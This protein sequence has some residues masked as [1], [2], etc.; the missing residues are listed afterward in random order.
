MHDLDR[1]T[2]ESNYEA[3]SYEAEGEAEVLGE[4][5]LNELTGGLL[6][7]GGE[8]E[9][10]HFLGDI[11]KKVTG[12]IGKILPPGVTKNLGGLLKAVAGKVLP[13]AGGALGNLIAPGIGGAIGSQLASNAGAALGLE[14]EGLSGEEQEFHVARRFV[15]LAAAAIRYA[16]QASGADPRLVARQAL[17]VAAQRYAPGLVPA[18]VRPTPPAPALSPVPAPTQPPTHNEVLGEADE[19]EL[20]AELMEA[21]SE[22]EV[23]HFIDGLIRSA[24][25]YLGQVVK[26]PVGRA[27]GGYLKQMAATALPRVAQVLD[28]TFGGGAPAGGP[29][30]GETY[31]S[32]A[33]Y[34]QARTLVR[35]GADAVRRVLASGGVDPL[36]IARQAIGG[37]ARQYAPDLAGPVVGETG[38]AAQEGRWVRRGSTIVLYGV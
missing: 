27:L 22:S 30:A 23:D 10:D 20:A 24:G 15:Q 4:N 9:L 38:G 34:E 35:L 16:S 17:Q 26:T 18:I 19:M 1:T 2:L 8:H 12:V 14:L 36:A 5:E 7:L 13:M 25:R 32:D 21:T 28:S 11:F 3:E 33:E 6:G 31:E 37:A 29:E